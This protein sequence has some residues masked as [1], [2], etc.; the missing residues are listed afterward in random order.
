MIS[1]SD[2]ASGFTL[3]EMIVVIAI[4]GVMMVLVTVSGNPIS[5]ATKAR[6]A[7][8]TLSGELRTARSQAV[9]EN[10]SIDV[11]LDL[12]RH[13]YRRGAG[14]AQL[15]P[16][17]LILG[18]LTSEDET[19]SAST[20]RIRFNADGSSSGGRVTIAGGNRVWWVGIDWLSG[21]VS[22]A[23]KPRT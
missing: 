15:L 23:E 12:T 9:T 21:R 2:P 16:P 3:I 5:P 1:R 22:L 18:L 7:A 20:G 13:V 6:A 10:R 19:V 8:E 14:P 4:L 17:E 11:T